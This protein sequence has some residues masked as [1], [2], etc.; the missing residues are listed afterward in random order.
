MTLTIAYL[1]SRK[2]PKFRWFV[3]S[4]MNEQRATPPQCVVKVVFVDFWK[5]KRAMDVPS[6]VTH[7]LPKP[8]VWQGPHRLTREDWFSAGNARNTALCYAPDGAIAYV[9]DL[10]VLR[11]GWLAAVLEGAN[12][13]GITCGAYRKVSKIQVESG[14]VVGH[15]PVTRARED[16]STF[17]AGLDSRNEMIKRDRLQTPYRCDGGW[18]FGCSL[19][20]PV[21][22]FLHINGWCE[23]LSGG[24]GFEDVLTGV[25]MKNAGL[26][27]RYDP[28]MMTYE[29]EEDHFTE[30]LFK[31]TDKG[32]SPHDKSHAA[33][34]VA[35]QLKSFDNYFNLRELRADI[36]R[37]GQFPIPKLP[38]V[39]WYDGQPLGE[40]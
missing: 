10:S 24:I 21:D 25:V 15:E 33:L 40:M 8:C 18:L 36:L 2:D 37:G 31:K 23:D 4:L 11:P 28:R 16:G 13:S 19:V 39:D 17:D 34:D 1:S 6:W 26:E 32:I 9:D 29:S 27:F 3:D 7:V 35:R 5:D 30:T 38:L 20:T 14:L 12:W 22:N